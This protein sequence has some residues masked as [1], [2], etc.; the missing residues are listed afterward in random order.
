MGRRT[1]K[2][3]RAAEALALIA[4]DRDQ[5]TLA[6][7]SCGAASIAR[8]P[9][10]GAPD[11]QVGRITLHCDGCGRTAVYLPNPLLRETTTQPNPRVPAG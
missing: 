11:E 9:P 6:C 4:A 2:E 7:P 8:T 1:I 10:R 5:K 3:F